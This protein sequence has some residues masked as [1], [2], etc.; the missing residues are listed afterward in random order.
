[1]DR[2][3]FLQM[4]AAFG[5]VSLAIGME[6]LLTAA[7]IPAPFPV[8]LT[9]EGGPSVKSDGTGTTID[10]LNALKKYEAPATFFAT[11]R[12]LHDWDNG[13]LSR[14]L[15]E[16]HAIGN[17]LYQAQ[18]NAAQDQSTPS[19]LAEQYLK[20]EK[21]LRSL[22][23][24]TNADAVAA[25]GKQPKLY[26]R[27]GGDTML[28]TFLD[29]ANYDQLAHEP[30]LKAYEDSLE[31]LK[32]VYDYSGWQVSAGDAQTSSKKKLSSV[33]LAGRVVN[34]A[35]GIQGLAAFLC[36]ASNNK[37]AQ[38]TSQGLVVQLFDNDKLTADAIPPIILQLRTKGAQ[39]YPL[40]RASDQANTFILGVED[41][42]TP[43]DSALACNAVVTVT[44]T[45]DAAALETLIP[46]GA[47]P[48]ASSS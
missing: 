17:R 7:S 30:F 33:A 26:R 31:W 18:G 32:T 21:R 2:R 23:Q 22:I 8:Y 40:P 10:V 27:P 15:A 37:R 9:F 1:M 20:T 11:G 46:P 14:M 47:T 12:E 29:P 41:P 44:P 39:F 3:T 16:G 45:S 24:G 36:N 6:R 34:G 28:G 5:V 48:D 35:K 42:P 19:Q 25:Y 43:D 4:S 38:E 13:T